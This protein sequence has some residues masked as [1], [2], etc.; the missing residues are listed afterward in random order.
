MNV[1]FV[2]SEAVPVAKSGGLADVAG[3]LPKALDVQDVKTSIVLPKYGSIKPQYLE[4]FSRIAEFEV[5][6]GWRNQYC[7]LWRGE[8]EGIT[9][10]LID[11]EHYFKRSGLYGYGDDAERFVFFSA[12]VLEA[13][14]YY[15]Q[16]FDIVHCNDWQTGL[17]PFL[18]RTRY[19]F[20]PDWSQSRSVYTIHNLMYQGIYSIDNMKELLGI[21]D[22]YFNAE[23]LE[24]FGNASCMKAGL[25]YADKLTTVSP[26]YAEEIQ[27]AY[28]GEKMESLLQY[29]R[30]DLIG[31][32]NGIDEKMFDP[33]TDTHLIAPYRHSLSRKKKNKTDLQAEMGLP[34]DADV[35]L[36]GVVSR[37]VEQKGFDLI[38]ATLDELLQDDVQI[39]I[40]GSGDEK[41][42]KYFYEAS[43]RH[44]T[45]LRFWLGYSDRIASRIYGGADLFLMP[46]RFEPCGL[47]Q[48]ISLRYRT[49]PIVRETGGLR[50]TVIPYNEY[51]YSG[52]G[53]TFTNYN[54]HDYL[55]TVRH[56]LQL[57][58][59]QE[60]WK[61]IVDNG[62]REDYSWNR[63]AKL[64]KK[65]YQQLS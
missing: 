28:Y 49:V 10:Y 9:Y 57:Y 15:G 37:L 27:T 41:Y 61:R 48:L 21:G 19:E 60:V 33:M 62:S 45:K 25:Q 23:G 55:Y 39:I 7:G 24:F 29:R 17:I 51:T 54:A 8:L 13:G 3:A 64:Y 53:F 65:L 58:S 1:L 44:P 56:A 36:L 59:D 16:K 14:P 18:L 34:Q 22:K 46:S 40:L 38:I 4:H 30:E 12:A 31:I 47:S 43:L 5:G 52:N 42:E 63:S 6:F 2:T 11:N 35:P 26:S 20:H 50:D 32:V